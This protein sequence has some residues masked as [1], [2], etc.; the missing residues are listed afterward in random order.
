MDELGAAVGDE[1]QFGGV[2]LVLWT[3]NAGDVEEIA[4]ET[5]GGEE[6]SGVVGETAGFGD[7]RRVRRM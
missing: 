7:G 1:A 4:V 3:Q 5:Q 6:V 2:V